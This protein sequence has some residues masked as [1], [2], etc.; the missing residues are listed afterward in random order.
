MFDFMNGHLIPLTEK[1]MILAD[2]CESLVATLW[3]ESTGHKPVKWSL[4]TESQITKDSAWQTVGTRNQTVRLILT[5]R[6]KPAS[7][8]LYG[9]LYGPQ[10][11]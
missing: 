6:F 8:R 4:T 5:G 11:L 10:S 7:P 9:A 2:F 3:P 1:P